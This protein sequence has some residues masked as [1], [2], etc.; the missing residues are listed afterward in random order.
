MEQ[1]GT[2]INTV[3]EQTS[4]WPSTELVTFTVTLLLL[5]VTRVIVLKS[6]VALGRTS[7]AEQYRITKRPVIT[8]AQLE[9]ESV[10]VYGYFYDFVT[11]LIAYYLG[12]F[13][14]MT[15]FKVESIAWY[16]FFHATVVEFVYYWFH[17]LLHVSFFYK[18]FHSYH[19]KSINTEPTTGV[20]F[21]FAERF[22]Y[23][24]LFAVS[25]ICVSLVG[26]NSLV[27]FFAY[28]IWFDVMNEGGHINFEILPDWFHNSPLRWIFYSPTFHSI[29]HTKFK[30]NFTLF[31]PWCDIL[32][33]T[34]I[35]KETS[36]QPLLPTHSKT[37]N[38][39]DFV[40]LVHAG[41]MTSVLY[42]L[43]IYPTFA[44]LMKLTHKYQ[45][46]PWMYFLYPYLLMMSTYW[47]YFNKGFHNEEVFDF[48]LNKKDTSYKSAIGSTWIVRN[49]GAHY[50]MKS[51]KKII[52]KRIENAILEAQNQGIKVVG[53]GNFN[54]AEWINHGGLDIVENLKDKLHS[55]YISHGDTLSAAVVYQ[56]GMWLKENNYWKKAVFVTGS[57]SKIGRALCLQLIKQNIKVYMYTQCKPR[58]DEIAA[59]ADPSLRHLLIFCDDLNMGK[60]CDLWF[61]GKMIPRGKELISA[62][63]K[64]ATIVNF[65]VP[66]PL[67]PKLMAQ[68]PDLLHLD[69]GLLQ[70][71]RQVMD[72]KFTWLLPQGNIY[73][74][75][76]GCIVHSVLGIEEHEVG[77]VKIEDMDKYWNAALQ[78][79]FSIPAHSS[80]YSPIVM[81]PPR[82]I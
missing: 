7:F 43:A 82:V 53:L 62:I 23:T 79:G 19:H 60:E 57:T 21:E 26:C 81:P 73:A 67:S 11:A 8:D 42:S 80:F 59:E 51:Y 44:P 70:Y 78:L 35:Y 54:K 52:T 13:Q 41:Y 63:P 56:Y 1:V 4:W 75:L 6:L 31:M 76:G 14:G 77:P 5:W 36:P 15:F 49:L 46:Q 20:S 50:L 40:L 10:W 65:A 32:F 24:L 2:Q 55:T 61:T 71:D 28:F 74:C 66:D 3:I 48:S 39:I 17:R 18:N 27:T 58:F 68:R 22:S 30:K 69:S 64:Y 37:E 16:F 45:H 29:H 72:P 38:K 47:G 12:P 25:P 9:R 34:A 33:G